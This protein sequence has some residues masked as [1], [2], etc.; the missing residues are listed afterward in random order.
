MPQELLND[1]TCVH[2]GKAID[3]YIDTETGD[4]DPLYCFDR[5]C[6]M[7]PE[8]RRDYEA[9]LEYRMDMLSRL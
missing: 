4:I 8:E 5:V 7:T 1:G 9:R 6:M 2:C 3:Q